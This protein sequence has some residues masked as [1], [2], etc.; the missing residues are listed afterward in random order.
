MSNRSVACRCTIALC[1]M[2]LA[3]HLLAADGIPRRRNEVP[4][5]LNSGP[6]ALFNGTVTGSVLQI[7]RMSRWF[8]M[9]VVKAEGDHA[10]AYNVVLSISCKADD[11]DQMLWVRELQERQQVTVGVTPGESRSLVLTQYPKPPADPKAAA[12]KERKKA[13]DAAPTPEPAPRL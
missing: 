10:P 5:P 3:G 2:V 8:T 12:P 4:A 11:R 9:R 13:K 6:A 7:D 1:C